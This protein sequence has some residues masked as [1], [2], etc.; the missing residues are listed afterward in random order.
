MER[1]IIM[2]V[3]KTM[4]ALVAHSA[5]NYSLDEIPVPVPGDGEMLIKMEVCGICAGDVK[6]THGTARFWGGEGNPPYCEVPFTPGHEFV[7]RVVAMGKNVAGNFKVG[8]RVVSE[9]IVPCG[10]CYYCRRGWYWLCDPHNVYGFKYYLNGGM[11]EYVIL[12][13]GSRNYHVPDSFT[14]EQAALIE[15]FACSLHGVRRANVTVDDVVVV[16]GAGTLGLGMVGALRLRNPKKLVVLDLNDM[17]LAKAKEFGAD[18][19]L[20][21]SKC[22]LIREINKL[23]DGVGCD[24]YIEVTGHPDAVQQGLD[25]IRKGGTFVEF[26]VMS[27]SST[28]DWSIIGDSKELTIVGSQLS[29]YCYETVISDIESGRMPTAGVVT[30][31]YPL[32]KW[33]EGFRMAQTQESIKV[34]LTP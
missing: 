26:S 32:E 25:I 14:T 1:S 27:G 17:R 4:K 19:L 24:V 9:Q 13:A 34:V 28:V 8:A 23:T 2:D 3:P 30:H 11:A 16:A 5:N 31:V 29:P 18:V 20:N 33:A 21:P 6:A 22:D 15:P 12:P 7:G 10:E